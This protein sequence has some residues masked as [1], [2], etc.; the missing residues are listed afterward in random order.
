LGDDSVEVEVTGAPYR[1]ALFQV[2][3]TP[4]RENPFLQARNHQFYGCPYLFI[5]L[6][7]PKNEI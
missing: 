4:N 6:V 1:V 5:G 3:L 7:E 2:A